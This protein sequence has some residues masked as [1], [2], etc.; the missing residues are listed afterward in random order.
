MLQL[1]PLTDDLDILNVRLKAIDIPEITNEGRQQL[2]QWRKD[3]HEEV[4]RLFQTKYHELDR[5][6]AG[7]KAENESESLRIRSKIDQFI[8]NEEVMQQDI[9]LLTLEI[10]QLKA[11]TSQIEQTQIQIDV[12]P[13]I[14]DSDS[15]EIVEVNQQK[16]D[17]K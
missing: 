8:L 7:R 6:I 2:E 13:L 9:D 5:L 14:I 17:L 4:D 11:A 15:I 3:C 1:N 16:V 12:R 10:V